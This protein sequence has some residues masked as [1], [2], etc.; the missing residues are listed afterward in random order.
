MYF[1]LALKILK[2]YLL[3]DEAEERYC[4]KLKYKDSGSE[5]H[6]LPYNN[7]KINKFQTLIFNFI[8]RK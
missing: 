4:G 6:I 7:I 5:R 2:L 1:I 8:L 3:K